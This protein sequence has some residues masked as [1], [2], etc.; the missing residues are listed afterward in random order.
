MPSS[1]HA[2]PH[3]IGSGRLATFRVYSVAKKPNAIMAALKWLKEEIESGQRD[4]ILKGIK[5]AA[6]SA[7]AHV[8]VD[9]D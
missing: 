9:E 1:S 7:H 6:A 8:S 3:T 4:A 2:L 5:Q